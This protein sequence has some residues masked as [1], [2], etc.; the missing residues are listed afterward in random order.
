[1]NHFEF[2]TNG[3]PFTLIVKGRA[4]N[5]TNSFYTESPSVPIATPGSSGMSSG[6]NATPLRQI[7]P[8]AKKGSNTI[9][10][11]VVKAAMKHLGKGKVEF[12]SRGQ[13]YIDVTDSTAN[14]HYITNAVQQKWG[15]G[16]QLVT[17]D[18][19]A[20]EDSSGTQGAST[21]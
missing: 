16:F 9:N 20:L 8:F 11:K 13:T 3:M 18:G 10:V 17:A 19:L 12:S 15:T 7:V 1:M 6:N 2:P 5:T 4:E 14:V 21:M